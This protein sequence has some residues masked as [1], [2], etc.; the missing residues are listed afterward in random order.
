MNFKGFG[1]W[2]EVF[3]GGR[4]VDSEGREHDGDQV[5]DMAVAT[6]DPDEHEPPVVVGHPKEDAPAFAWVENL[7]TEIKNGTKVL[8]AKFRDVVPEFEEMVRKGLFKK[9]S[10]SFYRDG[11][12]KHVGFLGAAAPAV[13]GMAN[14]FDE[15]DD[16]LTFDF[17][18]PGMGSV[19]RIL[20]NLRDWLIEK[21]GKE[22]ADVI[23]PD[24]DVEHIREEA[25]K[26]ETQAGAVPAFAASDE[27]KDAQKARAKK[28]GIAVKEKGHVTKPGEWDD[29]PDDQFLDPVNY[30]Y[31]CP[32]ADQTR[33]AAGYWGREKN[34]AQYNSKERS[35]INGRLDKFRKKFKIGEYAKEDK[36]MSTGFKEKVKGL[37]SFIGVDMSKVP[38]DA[39]PDSP[40]EGAEGKT[41]TEADLEKIRKDA[42]EAGRQKA[43]IEFNEKGRKDR[44]KA[45]EK[46][47]SDFC[48]NRMKEGKLLPAWEK[49]GLK[50]FML[51]LDGE[52][53]VEFSEESKVTPLDWFKSFLEELPK[54][55]EF[56]EIASRD[57]DVQS[58]NAAAKI[59]KLIKDKMKENKDL[60]YSAAFSEVQTEN[61]DLA[62]EYQNEMKEG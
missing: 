55:V 45:Q 17:Y 39:L 18:D 7:K 48:E 9:R 6:F 32:D 20:R 60:D 61:P 58:G 54:V 53:V 10:A 26:E 38:E 46:E 42:E 14:V 56:K 59:D 62:Q 33:A 44:R 12:L 19:A 34:Q 16:A 50:E 49:M 28:Y 47:I 52:T 31:P 25:N 29:V 5:I 23:I 40:P 41:F 36:T 8:F 4:Q 1:D 15:E 27:E 35:I 43:E 51:K 30:R 24:W 3:K 21:E 13:K 22:I 57:A 11:R 37:L 2:I